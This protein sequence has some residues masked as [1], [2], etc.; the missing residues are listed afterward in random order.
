[1]LAATMG[2]E[3][4]LDSWGNPKATAQ[5]ASDSAAEPVAEPVA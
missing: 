4:P 1:M 3:T 5:F 2:D